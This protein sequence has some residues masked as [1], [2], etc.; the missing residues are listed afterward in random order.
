MGTGGKQWYPATIRLV[1]GDFDKEAP[2]QK[3][4]KRAA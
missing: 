2:K 3:R 1:A 4:R